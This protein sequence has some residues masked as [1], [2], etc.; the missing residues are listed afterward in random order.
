MQATFI[1]FFQYSTTELLVS[2]QEYN[3]QTPYLSDCAVHRVPLH[4]STKDTQH[5]RIP[6]TEQPV[7]LFQFYTIVDQN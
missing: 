2:S 3:I 4:K 7:F 5:L 6:S 1:L